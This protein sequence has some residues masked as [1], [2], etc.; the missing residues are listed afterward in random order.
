MSQIASPLF[1]DKGRIRRDKAVQCLLKQGHYRYEAPTD[2]Y[3]YYNGIFH[4]SVNKMAF[5]KKISD[6]FGDDINESSRKA[7]LDR[8]TERIADVHSVVDHQEQNRINLANGV[9][10]LNNPVAEKLLPHSSTFHFFNCVS[11][12]YDPQARCPEWKKFLNLVTEGDQERKWLIQEL[13]GYCLIPG[14]WMQVAFI[15]MGGGNNGKS[16]LLELLRELLGKESTSS[17]SLNELDQ[18]FRRALLRGKLANIS[19]EA[20]TGKEIS[21]DV[22]KNLVSGGTITAEEKN[23]PPFQF[24]NK[25]KII[26]AANKPPILKEQTTALHRRLIVIPFNYEIKSH[27]RNPHI[28]AALKKECSGILNWAIKGLRRVQDN[29]SFCEC[30]AAESTKKKFIRD[31]DSVLLFIDECCECGPRNTIPAK[32]LYSAYKRFCQ[33]GGYFPC[34]DS[35]FGK[36]LK[37]HITSLGRDRRSQEGGRRWVYRGINLTE[38]AA[39]DYDSG[40]RWGTQH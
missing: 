29:Q 37:L 5:E 28:V 10:D 40:F 9:L 19:D 27:E 3:Y 26:T 35:E 20:P 8:F 39:S 24:E 23:K 22:F 31:S 36:R 1:D 16:T 30:A 2:T 6:L 18:K 13:F 14:N 4:Q 17:L 32:S 11:T 12:K 15:L 25:A 33:E 34:S 7:I 38:E 21:S